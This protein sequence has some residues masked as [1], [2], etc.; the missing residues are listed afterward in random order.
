MR[1]GL[2]DIRRSSSVLRIT[3]KLKERSTAN[4]FISVLFQSDLHSYICDPCI[5][6]K[7]ALLKTLVSMVFLVTC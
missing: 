3:K 7:C 2:I 1:K 6:S 4:S 5:Q